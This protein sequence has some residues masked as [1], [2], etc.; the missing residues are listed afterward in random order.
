MKNSNPSKF[1][2]LCSIFHGS[3][4]FTLVEILL[5]VVI[6]LIATAI[7]VPTFR[8]TFQS[9]QMRDAVRSTVR[10]SRYARSQ[11]ILRQQPCVLDFTNGLVR[12]SC[13]GGTNGPAGEQ[14][15]RRFPEDIQIA[16]FESVRSENDKKRVIF[17]ASG[18]N[19]GFEVTLRDRN[20]RR[21]VI[22]CDPYSGKIKVE[23]E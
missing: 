1:E 18:M 21:T 4:G 10:I 17:H 9:T 11:S 8:G 3:P 5:V 15:T 13:G 20:D 12:L 16:D 6:I 7:A 22:A 19:D 2:I 23:E 14:I